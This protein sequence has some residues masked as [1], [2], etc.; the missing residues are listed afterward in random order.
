MKALDEGGK[1]CNHDRFDVTLGHTLARIGGSMDPTPPCALRGLRKQPG[2]LNELHTGIRS[3]AGHGRPA[4][5]HM[6]TAADAF[7][8]LVTGLQEA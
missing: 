6:H 8:W 2:G 5:L 1:L 4:H 3:R 7:T